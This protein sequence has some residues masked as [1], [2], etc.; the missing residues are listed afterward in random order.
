MLIAARPP[1]AAMNAPSSCCCSWLVLLCCLV[2]LPTQTLAEQPLLD[3]NP[4]LDLSTIQAQA[5]GLSIVSTDACQAIRMKSKP[6]QDWP[7][8]TLSLD[9]SSHDFSAFDFLAVDVRNCGD[10]QVAFAMRVDSV[11]AEHRTDTKTE[12]RTLAPGEQQTVR[13]SLDRKLPKHLQGRLVGM[14]S[15]PAG[16]NDQ[17]GLAVDSI[18]QIILFV[19]NQP[20]VQ[21]VEVSNLRAAGSYA[22]GVWFDAQ[23]DPFPMI[24]SFGQ[25]MHDD[26][27]GKTHSMAELTASVE[28][29]RNDLAAHP[30][31]DQWDEFGGYAAGPQWE[32]SQR[33]RVQ[34]YK[35][36]WWLI[37]PAGH[38][39]WSHGIDCVNYNNATTPIS[40]REFYFA[41]LPP[42]NS[43]LAMFYG[44]AD[45]AP[46]GY[47]QGRGTY[48]TFNF[49]GANLFRK[50]G[51]NWQNLANQ[52]SHVRLRSWGMNTIANWS[53]ASI[54]QTKRTPYTLTS[55]TGGRPIE[56]SS[57]Y[58]GRFPDPFDAEFVEATH[59][60]IAHLRDDAN[61]AWCVGVFVD[62]ELAWGNETSLAIAALQSPADQPAK[63]AFVANLRTKY[64]NIQSLNAEWGTEYQSWEAVLTEQTPPAVEKA[65]DDLRAFYTRLADEYFRVCRDAVKTISP[66]T[67]YLGCRF[68]WA[69]DLAVRSAA[70]Y[71]DVIA[72]NRYE[73][74]VADYKL[75]QGIDMPA[76]IGEYHFGALDRGLFHT[77]LKPTDDQRARANAYRDYVTG[78]LKN[79]IWV[80]AHWFQYG[81][82]AATGRGDGEN[83]QIGFVDLCDTP[84]VETIEV[85]RE[86]GHTMYTLRLEP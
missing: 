68:A 63:L 49:T 61:S 32:I 76:I 12:Q 60:Q 84:Y 57:G 13:L 19:F 1:N 58:W 83:Y 9:N 75:P 44:E 56:G 5:V 26:W 28:L 46:H 41:E 74:S 52:H 33:F 38:L 51:A 36:R 16:L 43:P 70:K 3:I 23:R 29:E 31:P 81:D 72:Y 40:D 18:E 6:N 66:D 39:F 62:N 34:K 82:Q 65:G 21:T 42:P 53:E 10:Q 48:K 71:C 7:G 47:Y 73:Y 45:W 77:G 11:D 80:G 14:R 69:N 30:A 22:A 35:D 8:I 67:L 79:P 86:I 64:D 20:Y 2:W 15:N 25:F 24:D 55:S 85:A 37:D 50:Y 78:A 27:L 59:R 4:G 54:Y 17:Q